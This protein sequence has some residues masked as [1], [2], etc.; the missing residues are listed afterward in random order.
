LIRQWEKLEN[1]QK[2][3]TT[4]CNFCGNTV[5][6]PIVCDLPDFLLQRQEVSVTFVKCNVCGLIYQNPRPTLD[7]MAFHYPP[8]YESFGPEPDKE[9]SSWLLKK[10]FLYG[11]EK[12]C[13]FVTRYKRAGRLLDV[14]CATGNF[15]QGIRRYGNWDLFGV[16]INDHA[17]Q[18]AQK[19]GL[20]VRAGTLEQAGFLEGYFDVVTLWDVLEHLHNPASSLR[21]IFRI[22]KPDGLLVIRVPNAG[23]W[24]FRLFGRFWAGFDA[25]RHLYVFTPSIMELL[26]GKNN[27]QTIARSSQIGAYSTFLLSLRFWISARKKP[28]EL[29][30]T[31]TTVLQHPIMR[32]LFAPFFYFWGI[33]L[34]GPSLVIT[35]EKSTRYQND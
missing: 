29:L 5:A 22:L 9:E 19:L 11:V 15:L 35:A 18:I 21:E 20:N 32:L 34:R 24:D 4:L 12:R 27:F 14:G 33:G 13:R 25:P 28:I 2:M 1:N 23:S 3:E 6:T 26:L 8:D 7:E 30:E 31:L 10:A 16:E 17:A